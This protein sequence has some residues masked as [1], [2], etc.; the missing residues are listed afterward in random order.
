MSY[1]TIRG[2]ILYTSL[3]PERMNQERGREYFSLTVQKDA[4]RVLHAHCEIDDEPAV[5][6]DIV[7]SLDPSNYPLDCHCRLTVGHKFEGS[8]WFKFSSNKAECET[9]N[10]RDGRISQTIEL[11]RPIRWL[12]THPIVA[13]GMGCTVFDLQKGLGKQLFKD[14]ALTSPDHRGATGPMLFKLG[15][16]LEYLGEKTI[17]VP[18]GTFDCHHFSFTDTADELP[19]EHPQYEVWCTKDHFITVAAQAGGYMQTRYELVEYSVE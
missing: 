9:F 12:G 5:I 2:K 6:R 14:M 3:K 16:G 7:L 10:H 13:D 15:Y 11:A 18:A 4:C 8:G 19:E 17:T 1:K